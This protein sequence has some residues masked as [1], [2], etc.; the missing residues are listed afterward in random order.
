MPNH[1]TP[2]E[3]AAVLIEQWK[4]GNAHESIDIAF[5]EIRRLALEEAKK[6]L[7]TSWCDP[8]LQLLGKGP[9]GCPEIEAFVHRLKAE[10]DRLAREGAV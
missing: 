6:V 4:N 2:A 1:L 10:L 7:P 3:R 8:I 9:W 5:A